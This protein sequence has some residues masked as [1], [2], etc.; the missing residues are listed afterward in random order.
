MYQPKPAHRAALLLIFAGLAFGFMARA[1]AHS[2]VDAQIELTRL[3]RELRRAEFAQPGC[4][5]LSE[6]PCDDCTWR[7]EVYPHAMVVIAGPH[8]TTSAGT[9][10][11]VH[12]TVI[13]GVAAVSV[14]DGTGPVW[15]FLD[16]CDRVIQ[17]GNPEEFGYVEI[18]FCE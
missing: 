6:G 5:V 12:T 1:H 14:D 4:R 11:V 8:T 7:V 10:P 2:R 16:E 3:D 15:N 17:H 13:H 9:N 18:W